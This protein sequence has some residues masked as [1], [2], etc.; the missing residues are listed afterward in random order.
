MKILKYLIILLLCCSNI[1]NC[2]SQLSFEE[3]LIEARQDRNEGWKV[4]VIYSTSIILNGIGDGL[5]DSGNKTMGHVFNAGSI[6]VLLSSPF[7]LKYDDKWYKYILSYTFIR[8]G[9][10]DVTYNMTRHLPYNYTG[11]TSVTD[12]FYNRMG[13]QPTFVRFTGFVV[14][15]SLP[16]NSIK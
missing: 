16:L 13:G 11:S 3:Q 4:V 6:G 7:I 9:L 1:F 15:I 2:L 5:N 14:G 8:I 12:K 10:F